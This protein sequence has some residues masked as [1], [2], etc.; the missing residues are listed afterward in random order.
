MKALALKKRTKAKHEQAKAYLNQEQLKQT[1]QEMCKMKN[2]TRKIELEKK[3]K[4]KNNLVKL[5]RTSK[6]NHYN[7]FKKK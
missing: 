7:N 1:S 2:I 6:V 4:H 5:T 3:V